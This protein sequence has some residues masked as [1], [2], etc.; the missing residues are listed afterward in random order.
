[1]GASNLMVRFRWH[2][3][4][5]AAV[6]IS[7]MMAFQSFEVVKRY[8]EPRDQLQRE[9]CI[10]VASRGNFKTRYSLHTR[11]RFH[12]SFQPSDRVFRVHVPYQRRTLMLSGSYKSPRGVKAGEYRVCRE[13]GLHGGWVL[14]CKG[15]CVD[16]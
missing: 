15:A 14:H 5:S 3:S 8:L 7:Q 13:G 1:M 9:V 11:K 4:T 6:S 16:R 2:G 10:S 12:M